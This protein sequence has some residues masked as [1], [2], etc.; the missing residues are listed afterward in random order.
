[1]LAWAFALSWP[2]RVKGSASANATKLNFIDRYSFFQEAIHGAV[3]WF[4]AAGHDV[5]RS[6]AKAGFSGI[7]PKQEARKNRASLLESPLGAQRGIGSAAL[8]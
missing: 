3:L 2:V 6:T 1:V 4:R 7:V 8:I 5:P